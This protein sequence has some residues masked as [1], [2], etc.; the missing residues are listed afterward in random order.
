M[1]LDRGTLHANLRVSPH[2]THF[3]PFET[4][5]VICH[6]HGLRIYVTDVDTYRWTFL[7][8]QVFSLGSLFLAAAYH[9]VYPDVTVDYYAHTLELIVVS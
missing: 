5:S 4:G 2:C 7:L 9:L 6:T 1:R 8:G 3:R